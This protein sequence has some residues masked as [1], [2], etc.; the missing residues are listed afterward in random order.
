MGKKLLELRININFLMKLAKKCSN[1]VYGKVTMNRTQVSAWIQ[2]FQNGRNH[3]EDKSK[4][5]TCQLQ[6]V[7]QMWKK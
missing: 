6:G 1:Q 2:Q 5:A 4:L 7:I 3:V